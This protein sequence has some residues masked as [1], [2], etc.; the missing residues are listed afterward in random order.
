MYLRREAEADEASA[1]ERLERLTAALPVHEAMAAAEHLFAVVPLAAEHLR[2]DD[3]ARTLAAGDTVGGL[4]LFTPSP[5][6]DSESGCWSGAALAAEPAA[7]SAGGLRLSGNLRLASRLVDGALALARVASDGG[8][9]HHLVWIDLG[10]TSGAARSSA[11]DS[12]PVRHVLDGVE[13]GPE[14]VSEALD[15][16]PAGGLARSVARY[17]ELWGF[18]A[19]S[20]ARAGAQGLRRA[21]RL[22]GYQA[23]Q[24]VAMPLT[25]IEIETEAAL[26]AVRLRIDETGEARSG[27][28]AGATDLSWAA[29]LSAARALDATVGATRSLSDRFAL[30]PEGPLAGDG[31]QALTA[32]L[33]G[34]AFL[35]H[36]LAR[37]LGIGAAGEEAR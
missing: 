29:A 32:W 10:S 25:E 18:A 37:S 2:S 6:S 27:D 8:E 5:A 15:L 1:A 31:T 24:L 33:G 12:A 4:G 26:V 19:A 11:P 20:V 14:L 3:L 36:E 7:E 30:E 23:H 35:E 22:A 34:T 21:A 16:S 17:A 13:V 28:P 9:R